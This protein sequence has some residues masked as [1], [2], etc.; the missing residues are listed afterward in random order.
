LPNRGFLKYLRP[1]GVQ[2]DSGYIPALGG[3]TW[4][5]MFADNVIE[6]SI[7]YLSNSVRDFGQPWPLRNMYLYTEFNYDQLISGPPGQTFPQ[8]LITPGI[9]FMNYYVEL[10]IATQ[11]ALNHATVPSHHAAVLG[12]LDIFI[13]DVFPWVNWTPF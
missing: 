10:S 1:F 11:F 8:I 6:Y 2:G 3:G 7:P 5:E 13:D 12:L 9:A 4:D